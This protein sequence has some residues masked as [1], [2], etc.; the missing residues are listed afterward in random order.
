MS[1]IATYQL[2]HPE[3]LQIFERFPALEL[4]VEQIVACSPETLSVTV[5]AE[6]EDQA[7]FESEL[8]RTNAVES[9]EYR[10]HHADRTL[11]QIRTPVSKTTYWDWTGLGGVLLD[12]TATAD[13]VTMR[14]RFPDREALT[15]YRKCCRDQGIN[16]TLTGLT[17][18]DPDIS[19]NEHP[20]TS[21]QHELLI[22]AIDRGYFSIPRETGLGELA[23]TF[24][25]SDQAASERLRRG[26]SNLLKSGS[27]N[28]SS[29][30]SSGELR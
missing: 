11:Y 1:I 24:E 21:A 2:D 18:G 25:I 5:W 27:V 20:L 16:F 10:D 9:I 14:M 23:A 17:N 8:E 4:D 12:C 6:T 15:T 28:A 19:A 29:T 22:V 30:P 26:L 13:G 7:A 3:Y